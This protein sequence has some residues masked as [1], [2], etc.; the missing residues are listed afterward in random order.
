M[1]IVFI[2]CIV[3]AAQMSTIADLGFHW[4]SSNV[5]GWLA[6][7]ESC[8]YLDLYLSGKAGWQGEEEC[9]ECLELDWYGQTE[10]WDSGKGKFVNFERRGRQLRRT[11][12]M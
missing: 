12:R 10:S 5:V 11:T 7:L 8:N 6:W 3:K 2:P 9:L 1:E 4:D